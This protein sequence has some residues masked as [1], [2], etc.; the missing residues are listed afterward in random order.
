VV[1][2]LSLPRFSELLAHKLNA[3]K[4][5]IRRWNEEVVGKV[6]RKKRILLEEL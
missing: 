2:L 6:G 3:L 1:E 5:D 4:V